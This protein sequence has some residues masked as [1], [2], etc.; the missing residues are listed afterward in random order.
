MAN[1]ID[2][3]P[4]PADRSVAVR[5][6]G[7]WATLG[8]SLLA[9]TAGAVVASA[10]AL[11]I[12][13]AIWGTDL[14][15]YQFLLR[16][17]MPAA[18]AI[19]ILSYAVAIAMLAFAAKRS[20]WSAAEY[21]AL[22]RPRGRHLLLALLCAVVLLLFKFA[23]TAEF[24]FS[25]VVQP[26]GFDRARAANGVFLHFIVLAI[27]APV[28]E[29]ILFRGFLYRGLS[30]SRL[31]VVGTIIVTA[32]MFGLMHTAKG[33]AGMFDT[34]VGGVLWGWLRWHTGSTWM[35]VAGHIANNGLVSLLIL[36]ALYGWF[37]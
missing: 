12:V 35:P 4:M 2:I 1:Q 11:S 34:A 30:A 8:W 27:A 28:M 33:P 31:G 18:S 32:V 7:F 6:W 15:D 17:G 25:Q 23:H 14:P 21:L 19:Q 20:G 9:F 22:V 3:L 16:T 10:I 5:P 29:E 37:G 24:D 26:G 13:L 36:A